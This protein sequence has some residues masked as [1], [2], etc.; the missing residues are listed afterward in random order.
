MVPKIPHS[1]KKDSIRSELLKCATATPMQF[2]TFRAFAARVGMPMQGPWKPIL[3]VVSAEERNR[4]LPVITFLLLNRHTRYPM[5]M[6]PVRSND[7]TPE[8]R[9][10]ARREV[11]KIIDRYNP[12]APN[13]F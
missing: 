7:P 1:D 8:Q 2:P 3:D 12:G 11:Q 4:G 9:E 5:Q 10:R 13:P 6:G